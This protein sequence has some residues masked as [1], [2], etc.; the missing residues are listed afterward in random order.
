MTIFKITEDQI[1]NG[2]APEIPAGT[3]EVDFSSCE[4]LKTIPSIPATVKKL[5]LFGCS[6]LEALPELHE[7]LE[8][9]DCA[10]CGN[11][12]KITNVPATVRKFNISYCENLEALPR[13]PEELE[14]LNCQCCL[15]LKTITNIPLAAKKVDL[16]GC[17]NIEALPELPEGL[18]EL[19]YLGIYQ[20]K[21]TPSTLKKLNLS[22]C[23]NLEALP[24]LHEG[25]EELDCSYCWKLTK[26]ID[27]PSTLKKL[28]L[29]SKN[30]EDTPK[31]RAQLQALEDTDCKVIYPEHFQAITREQ[32]AKNRLEAVSTLYTSEN[33]TS[34]DSKNIKKLMHD[35][36]YD[37]YLNVNLVKLVSSLNSSLKALEQNPNLL[38][39]FDQIAA[40]FLGTGFNSSVRGWMEISSLAAIANQEGIENK[41]EAAKQILT[42]DFVTKFIRELPLTDGQLVDNA[43]ATNILYAD[44]DI[45]N[46][47][48]EATNILHLDA[49]IV[50]V[51][52]TNILF[53]AIHNKL[54]A[55]G[56]LKNEWNII[57]E[58]LYYGSI[59]AAT[60]ITPEIIE[61]ATRQVAETILSLS[62]DEVAQRICESRPKKVWGEVLFPTQMAQIRQ[63]FLVEEN[64]D[65]QQ[66]QVS[67]SDLSDS[68]K[69]ESD[70]IKQ[71]KDLSFAE[72]NRVQTK[73]SAEQPKEI[74]STI[75]GKRTTEMLDAQNSSKLDNSD[76]KKIHLEP[77]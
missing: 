16:S 3:T 66:E 26:I 46:V 74:P 20:L 54:K 1:I 8:I 72:L 18:E 29:Y 30:L 50:G 39:L 57:T 77:F 11:L 25:L 27:L 5:D 48:V 36:V 10:S 47:G 37:I 71:L 9:L 56:A 73:E 58:K 76:A 64:N 67:A 35:F 23:A 15:A 2:V 22:D 14:Q 68:Q 28:Y 12:K 19:T 7:G 31:L 21:T 59:L 61:S 34:P 40:P 51:E 70:L 60:L 13:L 17:D 38:P 52:A 24:K 53:R 45:V 55:E 63:S 69:L 32:F 41:L 65:L 62:S 42:L 4:N 6:N 44:A 75:C 33:P 49:D 43:E